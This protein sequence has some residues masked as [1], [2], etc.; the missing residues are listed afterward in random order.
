MKL[1]FVSD[2]HLEITE[3]SRYLKEYLPVTGEVLLIAGDS[4]YLEQEHLIKHPFWKWAA[5]NYERVIAVPGNHE[6]YAFYDLASVPKS[7]RWELASNV[8][9]CSNTVEHIGDVDIIASTLWA[10][11][12][13]KDAYLNE[14]YVSDFYRIRYG[15]NNLTAAMFNKEHQSCVDFIKK[16]VEKSRATTKIVLTHHV[17]SPIVTAEEFKNSPINGSFVADLTDYIAQSDIDY[18]I[19]GHSHRSICKQIGKTQVLSNQLGYVS[20]RE[21]LHGFNPTAHIC[22]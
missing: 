22:V 2:L 13:L 16:S 3:N 15:K 19:Y 8:H 1:Q 17:P 20:K 5:D 6:Y 18:W 21:Y 10:Y 9:I 14:S 12:E 7:H 4:I 11:I